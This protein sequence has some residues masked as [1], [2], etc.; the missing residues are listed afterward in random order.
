MKT[1]EE[2]IQKPPIIPENTY[3]LAEKSGYFNRYFQL[4]P[5]CKDGKEAFETVQTEYFNKYKRQRFKN[6]EVFRST[7]SNYYKTNN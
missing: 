1:T 2:T 5:Y 4:L 6:Y 3:N 7:K